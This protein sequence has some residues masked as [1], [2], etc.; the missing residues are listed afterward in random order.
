MYATLGGW[1]YLPG[2]PPS[3]LHL[4]PVWVE[5]EG[6]HSAGGPGSQVYQE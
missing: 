2:V 5:G 3:H 1:W 4:Q 6:D